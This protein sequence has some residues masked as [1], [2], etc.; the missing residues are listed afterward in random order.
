[1]PF[2]LAGDPEVRRTLRADRQRRH[3]PPPRHHQPR[4]HRTAKRR[5]RTRRLLPAGPRGRGPGGTTTKVPPR[6]RYGPGPNPAGGA[7]S[8]WASRLAAP[9]WWGPSRA[10]PGGT[11]SGGVLER[12]E[13][14][15]HPAG[16]PLRETSYFLP[17]DDAAGVSL[18]SF[19]SASARSAAAVA[20]V[21]PTI[22]SITPYCSASFALI[23]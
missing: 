4:R 18:V 11:P 16:T 23:Q 2:W 20:S 22:V 15:W 1:M 3:R 19:T 8:A 13:T 10:N 5:R 17:L 12:W 14:Y 9:R 6:S 7:P 21:A